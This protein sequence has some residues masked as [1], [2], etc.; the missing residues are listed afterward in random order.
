MMHEQL[1]TRIGTGTLE[2]EHRERDEIVA[3]NIAESG[4]FIRQ[5]NV[6]VKC[7]F[8]NVHVK[9]FNYASL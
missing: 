4:T 5:E 1:M 9:K 8:E 6:H 7:S 2:R 3:Y